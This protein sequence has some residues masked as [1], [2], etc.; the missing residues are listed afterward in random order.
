MGQ[1][2]VERDVFGTTA[3]GVPVDRYTLRNKHGM[4]VRLITYGATVTELWT[5][6][7]DGN[8]ADVV[9]GFD[10]LPQY[11]TQ[12][13]YFGCTVGRVAFRI[14]QGN[15]VLDGKSHNLTLNSG[16]HHMHGGFKGFSWVVWQAEPI[17]TDAGP[18]VRFTYRSPDGDE[19]YPGTLDVAVVYT[20]TDANE[21]RI[22]YTAT[23]DQ[24]TLINLTHHS[25]F[26]LAGAGRGDVLGHVLQLDAD[27][28]IRAAVPEH[29]HDEIMSVKN[30][31]YDFNE[32]VPI[33]A[34]IDQTAPEIGGYDLCYLHNRPD[35]KLNRIAT[36]SEPVAGRV[37]DVS[38]TEPCIVVY[39]GN[40][41]DGSLQGKDRVVYRKYAGVCLETGRPPDAIHYPHFPSTILRPE[42][43]YNHTC[44][45]RFS[46]K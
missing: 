26:N 19:G 36:L 15:F 41:L 14:A 22:D 38:T 42:K 40:G 23:T 28:W 27:R 11:E 5:P 8:V 17:S 32:R 4:M 20:L 45:Y 16:P 6:D 35:G 30:T 12:S 18:G 24:P 34:R 7:R 13:P 2:D 37:M 46:T 39:T 21:L 1:M 3:D 33:G 44:V 43:P 25:Y 31:P 29:P 10:N 9:L